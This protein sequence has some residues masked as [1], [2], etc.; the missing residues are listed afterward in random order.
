M[1][2]RGSWARHLKNKEMVAEEY[3]IR[4][5]LGIQKVREQG[6]LDNV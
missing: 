3:L 4:H 1:E 2:V 6:E 5:F